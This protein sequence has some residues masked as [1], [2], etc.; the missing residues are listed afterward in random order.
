MKKLEARLNALCS[1]NGKVKRTA[2]ALLKDYIRQY[3]EIDL[4]NEDE[5]SW[6][7]T[8]LYAHGYFTADIVR[9]YIDEEGLLVMVTEKKETF[10]E[11]DDPFTND[12]LLDI[13]CAVIGNASIAK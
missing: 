11:N 13:L 6:F 8:T 12:T 4:N 3:G 10:N 1:R 2:L 9:V 7:G 5:W